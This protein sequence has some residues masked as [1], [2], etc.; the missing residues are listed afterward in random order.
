MFYR[1]LWQV[2]MNVCQTHVEDD[3]LSIYAYIP[4]GKLSQSTPKKRG[5]RHPILKRL[6]IVVGL[7]FLFFSLQSVKNCTCE[8]LITP[9]NRLITQ[10]LVTQNTC[11]L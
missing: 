9:S 8:V 10:F 11:Y 7:F 2:T 5:F 6:T 4:L 1:Q 3:W